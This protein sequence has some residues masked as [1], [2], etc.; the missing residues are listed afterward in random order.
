MALHWGIGLAQRR[1]ATRFAPAADQGSDAP[2]SLKKLLIAWAGYALR[3]LVW[4]L[5]FA[6]AV[7][8]IPHTRTE[9]ETVGAKLDDIRTNLFSWLLEG[10]I[11]IIIIIVI[12]SF[13]M[14]F[15][16]AV[17]RTV[18]DLFERRA[19]ARDSLA[20]RRRYQTLSAILRGT[21]QTVISFIGLMVLL[22]QLKVDITPILASAGVVGIAVGFGAQS[23]IKD[24]FS[25]FLILLEDHYS[26]GDT[27]K[28][29]DVTG[30]VEH[31]TLRLTR[32]RGMDGSL[33]SIPN[34]SITIVSNLS[35]DWS[36]VVLDVEVSTSEDVDRAMDLLFDTAKQM[37]E[38][39]PGDI[40]EEPSMLGI[41]KLSSTSVTL[42]LIV[43]TSP[44]KNLEIGRELRRR[45][46][47]AFEREGIKAPM[48]QQQL[49]MTNPTE[50]KAKV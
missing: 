21:A 15:S 3:M 26:V 25:G 27:V 8:L 42:R 50:A 17:I 2:P 1:F 33:T 49:V 45:I 20:A 38:E 9:V 34:G 35:K 22:N 43:K 7:N 47:L 40:L 11:N 12:T 6:F 29:G 36:R 39:M 18:F 24:I 19:F 5:Y 4:F 13:L 10:G 41:D 30:T 48:P 23:L 14:R 46:K 44:A 28:I 31:L 16:S 32:I 37:K